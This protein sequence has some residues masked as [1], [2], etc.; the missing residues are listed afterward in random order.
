MLRAI[1]WEI[2]ARP[3]VGLGE[4]RFPM[5]EAEPGLGIELDQERLRRFTVDAIAV[6][7]G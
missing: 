3:W 4:C 7:K 5:D 1:I 6:R 2:A